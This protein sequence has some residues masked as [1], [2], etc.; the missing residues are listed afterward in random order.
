MGKN[1]TLNFK[2]FLR[3]LVEIR[4]L[5]ILTILILL[6]ATLSVSSKNFL[7]LSNIRVIFTG[8]SY[9]MIVCAFMAITLIG[10]M[11]DFSVG[12]VLGIGGFVCSIFLL[13]GMNMWIAIVITLLIGFGLGAINGIIISKLHIIPLVATMGTWMAYK[14]LGLTLINNNSIGNLPAGIKVFGQKWNLFG[15]PFPIILMVF[16]VILTWFLLKY[17]PFFHRAFYIG[18]N[19]DSA[20][21]AG[22]NT[23][24]FT[25]VA[26]GLTATAAALAGI[27]SISRFGSAPSTMGQGLEFKLVTA[28]L[29]GGVSFSGGGGSILGA[30]LGALLMQIVT[31]ALALFNIES[32]LQNVFVGIILIIAVAMDEYNQKRKRGI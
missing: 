3:S 9:E 20:E 5:T 18:E 21:L 6:I 12:S 8:L 7:T 22:I 4:E 31:N 23:T 1:K 25:I 17:V 24:K 11:I 19:I 15:I 32:N 29:I 13:Q 30:L 26:Y 10:G 27:L 14:G 16:V 2:S 28:L